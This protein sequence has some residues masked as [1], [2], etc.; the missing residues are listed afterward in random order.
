MDAARATLRRFTVDPAADTI[1]IWSPDGNRIVFGSDRRAGNLDLYEKPVNGVQS[2][3]ILL[4][5][6]ADKTAHDWSPDGRFILYSSLD[7][8]TRRDLWALPLFGDR[9]P[10]PFA[11]TPSEEGGARFSPDGRWVAYTSDESGRNEIYVQPFPGPGPK[12]Q[13]ST[14][15]GSNPEWRRDGQEVFY[16]NQDGPRLMAVPIALNGAAVDVGTPVALFSIPPG[17]YAVAPDGQRILVAAPSE[18]GSTITVVLNW[19]GAQRQR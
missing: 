14:E 1:P 13:I 8:K 11:R 4:E 16:T 15:G 3:A 5:S 7:P 9:T 17:P 19:A 12:M 18:Q 2:E 10:L 6:A